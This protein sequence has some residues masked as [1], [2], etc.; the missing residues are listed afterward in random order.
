LTDIVNN[1]NDC[2]KQT[3]P[4][5]VIQVSIQKR[6]AQLE[7]ENQSKENENNGLKTEFV[8]LQNFN[9][10][11]KETVAKDFKAMQELENNRNKWKVSFEEILNDENYQNPNRE[12]VNKIRF[13][14]LPN[15]SNLHRTQDKICLFQTRIEEVNNFDLFF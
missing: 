7:E 13:A 8:S 14:F 12:E 11:L 10:E 15:L 5:M 6:N 4:D 2:L 9:V 1:E 3:N